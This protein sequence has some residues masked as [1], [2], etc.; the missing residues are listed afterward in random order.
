MDESAYSGDE[1][2]RLSD[3]FNSVVSK[4]K[5]D[6]QNYT[7]ITRQFTSASR[8]KDNE[9]Y[10]RDLAYQYLES[11][12]LRQNKE[13]FMIEYWRHRLFAESKSHVPLSV[14]FFY[15]Q[16]LSVCLVFYT[17]KGCNIIRDNTVFSKHLDNFGPILAP[18]NTCIF[19][20]RKD[21]TF[22]GSNLEIYGLH[23]KLVR[24]PIHTFE[25]DNKIVLF[26]GAVVHKVLPYSGF[27]IRDCIVVM[28]SKDFT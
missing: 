16:L 2:T 20:L 9:I 22:K 23:G 27:G 14:K 3:I 26:E 6:K 25:T 11:V 28:F 5:Y 8:I 18:V 19:Y 12:G 21:K 17:H 13:R 24:K 10:I 1:H 7:Q 4:A 15:T